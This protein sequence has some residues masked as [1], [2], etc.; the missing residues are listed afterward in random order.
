MNFAQIG[1]FHDRAFFGGLIAENDE[2]KI[3]FSACH[4]DKGQTAFL[5]QLLSSASTEI[6]WAGSVLL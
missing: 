1:S 5:F 6:G 3:I 2:V 4:R